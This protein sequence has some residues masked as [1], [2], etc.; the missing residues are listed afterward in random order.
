MVNIWSCCQH[1]PAKEIIMLCL[2]GISGRMIFALGRGLTR[3]G[4]RSKSRNDLDSLVQTY[5]ASLSI[6]KSSE[7]AG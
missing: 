1:T 4:T 2:P 6:E 5:T 3:D 7:M